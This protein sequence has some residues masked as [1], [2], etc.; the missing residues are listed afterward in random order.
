VLALRLAWLLFLL[1]VGAFS[2][3]F[4]FVRRLRWS[5]L[6][7]L[8][9]SVGLSLLLL[10]AAAFA[11]YVSRLPWAPASGVVSAGCVVLGL[12]T[13]R[14]ASR[15]PVRQVVRGFGF[16]VAWTF[17]ILLLLRNYSGGMWFGDWLEHFQ[18]SLY[19]LHR[20]PQDTPIFLRYQL[21]ARPPFMN[22]LAAFFLA[23]AGDRFELF[24][25]VFTFL[26]L[27]VFLPCCLI[28]PALGLGGR[29]RIAPLAAVFACN[30]LVVENATYTWTKLLAAFFVVLGLWFYLAAWRKHDRVRL[31]A[32]SLALASALLVHYSAGPYV[33]L[34][35]L[36]YLLFVF[37]RRKEKWK[38]L[39]TA[40]TLGGTV[41]ATW[42]VWSVAT[43]GVRITFGSNTTVRDAAQGSGGRLAGIAA[44]AAGNLVRTAMPHPLRAGVSLDALQQYSAAGWWRDYFFLIYQTNAIFA[45]GAVGGLAV[46][47][48]LGRSCLRAP[49]GPQRLFWL[50]FLSGGVALATAVHWGGEVF[51]V[52][53]VTLQPLLV[54]GLSLL[55]GAWSSL[56]RWAR[57]ALVIGCALDFTLGIALQAKVESLENTPQERVFAGLTYVEKGPLPLG[58]PA[59]GFLSEPA[60]QNWFRKHQLEACEEW[61]SRAAAAAGEAGHRIDYALKL[62]RSEDRVYWHGWYARHDGSLVFL[63]DRTASLAPGGLALPGAALLVMFLGL[64]RRLLREV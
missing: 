21:P 12:L 23:P 16:L 45:M 33:V 2:P 13:L 63:G 54:L 53:H 49:P 51:G 61:S 38:E 62:Y 18:R 43:F 6:E 9:G 26:N 3:G 56:R 32:A 14:D 5:P 24:Q 7:K 22:L 25:V 30:P 31:W 29:R 50:F 58:P 8:C 41:L 36:H 1:P 35:A 52:A 34:L 47:Y 44:N 19:F 64:M 60:W 48:L 10:Y 4:F 11:I 15:L 40:A 20:F 55:G 59:A 37:R 46:L 57:L 42:L 28:A 39:A 27:L 17:A